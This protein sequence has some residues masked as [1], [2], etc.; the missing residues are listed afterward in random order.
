MKVS[1]KGNLAFGKPVILNTRHSE[2]YP[3][4]GGVALTNGLHGPNDY[5]CNWLGFEGEHMEAVVDFGRVQN[6]SRIKTNFLQ[7][8]YAWIWLPL[9]VDFSISQDGK[10][11]THVLSIQN[12]V[13]D[14]VGGVFTNEFI[15]EDIH[16]SARYIKV[17]AKSRLKCPDWHIGAGGKAW[18]FIDEIVVE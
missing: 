3:V 17:F 5:H 10:N 18:I 15:A 1:V 16:K 6:I 13:P 12:D 9:K 4:G 11:F 8:Y 7:Q 14:T 2:K